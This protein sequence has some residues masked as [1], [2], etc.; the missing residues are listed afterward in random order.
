M[1]EHVAPMLLNRIE[2]AQHLDPADIARF[3]ELQVVA[4]AQPIHATADSDM[5]ERLLGPE[6]AAT[7]YAWRSLQQ[8]GALL[9]FGSDSPV[10]TFDPWA[11][12]HAAVTR[13]RRDGHPQGGWHPEQSVDLL[14]ALEAYTVGPAIIAG[15]EHLRGRLRAGMRADLALLSTDPFAVDAHDLWRIETDQTFIDGRSVWEE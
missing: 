13:Q 6:R 11:G 9:A 14:T 2:H 8:A 10:E 3:G 4:S 1:P 15:E 12:I 5:A 7:S